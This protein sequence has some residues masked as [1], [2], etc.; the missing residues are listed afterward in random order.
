MKNPQLILKKMQKISE[1]VY[2]YMG[3]LSF[4]E[5]DFQLAFG[6]E[7]GRSKIDYLREIN[8]EVYYKDI[9]VR[10]GSPDF[11]LNNFIPPLIIELKLSSQIQNNHRQQLKM[12]LVSIKRNPKSVLSEVQH[13][14]IINFLKEDNF[15]NVNSKK[16]LKRNKI[17]IE[18]YKVDQDENMNL[19]KKIP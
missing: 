2:K 12:Y 17:E 4:D 14:I 16:K 3:G 13:G 10:L 7:L 1:E 8:L 11:F 15:F 9:P 5:K 6:Y 18:Y 19:I